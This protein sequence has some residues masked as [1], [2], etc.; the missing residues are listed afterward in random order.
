MDLETLKEFF[1]TFNT[2]FFSASITLG[3][4]LLSMKTFIIQI[5]KKDV[6]DT[7]EYNKRIHNLNAAGRKTNKYKPLSN[8]RHALAST[9]YAAFITAILQLVASLFPKKWLIITSLI[10]MAITFLCVF[11]AIILVSQNLNKLLDT[12]RNE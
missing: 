8:L 4:F 10:S 2:S 5:M 11:W 9:I 6:Y 3:A 12:K 1:N 7:E